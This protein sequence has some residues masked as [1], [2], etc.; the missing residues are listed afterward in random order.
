[1]FKETVFRTAFPLHFR[2][3][4]LVVEEKEFIQFYRA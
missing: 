3:Q 1:M 2:Q 4:T